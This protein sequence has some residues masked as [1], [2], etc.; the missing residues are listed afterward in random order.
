MDAGSAWPRVSAQVAGEVQVFARGVYPKA[1]RFARLVTRGDQQ[2]AE[3]LVQEAFQAILLNWGFVRPGSRSAWL[4]TVIAR[5]AVDRFRRD[6]RLRIDK[7]SIWGRTKPPEPVD[8]EWAALSSIALDKCWEV[9]ERMPERRH[10][11]AV[12]RW[13]LGWEYARIAEEMGIAE[14]TVRVQLRIARNDLIREVGPHLP[15]DLIETEGEL[16]R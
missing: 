14:G 10:L 3:D 16:P 13:R 11:V 4:R 2:L 7:S 12:L 8:T 5:R 9:I 1:I 6:A 15:F